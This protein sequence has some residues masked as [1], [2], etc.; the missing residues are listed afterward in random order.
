MKHCKQRQGHRVSSQQLV[1]LWE[2]NGRII[3]LAL[4]I[5]DFISFFS[6]H[7]T[8]ALK[9]AKKKCCNRSQLQNVIENFSFKGFFQNEVNTVE[10]TLFQW[11]CHY[12]CW[13]HPVSCYL[14]WMVECSAPQHTT[15][16][17]ARTIVTVFLDQSTWASFFCAHPTLGPLEEREGQR[18][19][20]ERPHR[21]VRAAHTACELESP[22]HLYFAHS[23]SVRLSLLHTEAE[24]NYIPLHI[25][26]MV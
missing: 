3:S 23:P 6:H 24:E 19:S 10:L 14:L 2:R 8:K 20:R 7:S 17:K 5:S 15:P 25:S 4:F 26:R 16:G 13:L 11:A 12:L 18:G 1:Q 9:M 21:V 22:R